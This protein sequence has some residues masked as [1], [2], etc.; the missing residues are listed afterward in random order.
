MGA[1]KVPTTFP[2]LSS[3][4]DLCPGEGCVPLIPSCA[5]ESGKET[6]PMLPSRALCSKGREIQA[7]GGRWVDC[8]YRDELFFTGFILI[9]FLFIS[10]LTLVNTQIRG[11]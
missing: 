7:G 11:S 8:S 9:R 5:L 10:S 2:P 4:A 1:F 6:G 3:S